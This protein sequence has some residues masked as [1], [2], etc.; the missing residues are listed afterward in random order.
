MLTRVLARQESSSVQRVE[1]LR[2]HQCQTRRQR[3]AEEHQDRLQTDSLKPLLVRSPSTPHKGDQDD[4]PNNIEIPHGEVTK[5][6]VPAAS[7]I[8]GMIVGSGEVAGAVITGAE[9]TIE[10]GEWNWKFLR[11]QVSQC[12][13]FVSRVDR[14]QLE[15]CIASDAFL[16][17][18]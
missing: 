9:N 1:L 3:V 14:S 11:R 4:P 2:L 16:V 13:R 18:A 15:A 17:F 7:P 5:R 10:I 6:E 12:F 8:T